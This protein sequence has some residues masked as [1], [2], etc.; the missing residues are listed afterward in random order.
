MRFPT[1][2]S[3]LCQLHCL[4]GHEDGPLHLHPAFP[5]NNAPQNST[6]LFSA[7][8][9]LNTKLINTSQNNL[10]FSRKKSPRNTRITNSEVVWIGYRD[11]PCRNLLLNFLKARGNVEGKWMCQT[12]VALMGLGILP[13]N[14]SHQIKQFPGSSSPFKWKK[15]LTLQDI[16]PV[17]SIQWK[18]TLK[19]REIYS[20]SHPTSCGSSANH[21]WC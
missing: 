19:L 16:L 13:G 2:I 12:P 6:Q 15:P 10:L 18:L 17:F 9:R 21:A 20:I 4:H 14:V 11:S 5:A 1:H 8:F 7:T 3:V